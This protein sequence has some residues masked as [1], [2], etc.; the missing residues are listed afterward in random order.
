MWLRYDITTA[1]T[2][3][4]NYIVQEKKPSDGVLQSGKHMDNC[5]QVSG[6]SQPLR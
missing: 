6:Q 1:Q 5:A 3:S 2:I 4:E